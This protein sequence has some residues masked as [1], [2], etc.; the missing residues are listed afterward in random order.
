MYG[1][2]V[3]EIVLINWATELG[4]P[5]GCLPFT[6]LGVRVGESHNLDWGMTHTVKCNF[7]FSLVY[8]LLST[9]HPKKP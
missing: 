8:Y 7:I 6:C 5:K 9:K 1:L 2:N 4:C 3:D